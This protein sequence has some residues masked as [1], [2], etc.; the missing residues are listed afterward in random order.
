M[1]F[2]LFKKKDEDSSNQNM[3]LPPMP[4]DDFNLDLS[5]QNINISQSGQRQMQQPMQQT[6]QQQVNKMSQN[7]MSMSQMPQ[8]QRENPAPRTIEDVPGFSFKTNTTLPNPNEQPKKMPTDRF[9]QQGNDLPPIADL[10]M[11]DKVDLTGFDS[12]NKFQAEVQM[13]K[14]EDVQNIPLMN[15]MDDDMPPADMLKPNLV[16]M[17]NLSNVK[18]NE[19][20]HESEDDIEFDEIEDGVSPIKEVKLPDMEKKDSE[21]KNMGKKGVDISGSKVDSD[22]SLVPEPS[23]DEE[24]P[25]PPPIFATEDYLE[26]EARILKKSMEEHHLTDNEERRLLEPLR[27]DDDNIEKPKIVDYD[28][29]SPLFVNMDGYKE[30]LGDIDNMKNE[31]KD[32]E[33]LIGRLN[34]IKNAKDKEF[35]KWRSELEDIQRKLLYVD[36]VIF[37]T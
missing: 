9:M 8:A 11:P 1:V 25:K 37:E 35:E 20:K 2:G 36:K 13:P 12:N 3:D 29:E 23:F 7:N 17:P 4:K 24:I 30:I 34:D 22:D 33:E 15:N 28:P 10:S 32:A 18:Q 21:K 27:D 6:N 31:L 14:I 5:G 19:I 16:N 26:K